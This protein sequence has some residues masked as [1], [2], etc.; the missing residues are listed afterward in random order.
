MPDSPAVLTEIA[1]RTWVARNELIDVNLTVIGG[2]RGLVVVDT[3][4]STAAMATM[5]DSIRALGAGQVVGVVNTHAHFDHVLGN[6]VFEGTPIHAHEATAAALATFRDTRTAFVG[7]EGGRERAAEIDASPVL[8]PDR[9]FS[10][11][12]VIDLGDRQVELLHPGRGHTDGDVI[13]RLPDADVV[14]LGDLVEESGPPAYGPDCW[15]MEWPT[16]LDLAISLMTDDTVVVPGH[17]GVSDSDF[18]HEQRGQIGV[19]AETIRDLAGRGIPVGQALAEGEWP[20]PE[21]LLD[22]AVRR[23]YAHLPRTAKRLPLI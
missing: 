2:E 1:D 7:S 22:Q 4:A 10:S 9:T 3:L 19:V 15:P 21:H 12:Q 17:G 14:V 8:L 11:A 20:W 18:V 23:G 5:L 13:V 16:A 6:A